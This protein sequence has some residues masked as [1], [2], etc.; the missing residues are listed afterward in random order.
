MIKIITPLLLLLTIAIQVTAT[1][2]QL[3]LICDEVAIELELAVES[4][5]IKEQEALDMIDRCL[6][7]T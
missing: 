6:T 2:T 4:G 1:P 5:H 7:T 3:E